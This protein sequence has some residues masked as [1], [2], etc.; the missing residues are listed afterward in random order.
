MIIELM[1]RFRPRMPLYLERGDTGH[2]D[3]NKNWSPS[4]TRGKRSVNEASR[5]RKLEQF[6]EVNIPFRRSNLR[7]LE[8]SFMLRHSV[9]SFYHSPLKFDLPSNL[10]FRRRN[11]RIAQLQIGFIPGRVV[12]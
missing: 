12:S 11:L 4:R 9:G 2:P 10:Y 3:G 6:Q 1:I 7:L 5:K 8:A